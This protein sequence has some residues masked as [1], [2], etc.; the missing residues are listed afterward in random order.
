MTQNTNKT[1]KMA[2]MLVLVLTLTSSVVLASETTELDNGLTVTVYGADEIRINSSVCDINLA[3]HEDR[4]VPFNNDKVMSALSDMHGFNIDLNVTVYLLPAPPASINSSYAR[5]NTIY[6]A[7]GTGTIPA[8]TQAYITTHEMGHVLCSSYMDNSKSRWSEY[9]E[10]RGLNHD[11]NGPAAHHADRAREIV[12]E[13]FRFLFGGGLAT[14]TGSIE[15]HNM[16][17]PNEVD[18]LKEL[19][20]EFLSEKVVSN[21]NMASAK[22][23]PNPCNPR[24]TIK[25]ELPAG[26]A[27]AGNV[28]LSVFDVRGS[29]V[30]TINGGQINGNTVAVNWNGDNDQGMGVSSG[31]YLYLI[32]AG[33]VSARGAVSLVR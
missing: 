12:A 26:S 1:K 23:F 14:S 13:D 7:P 15:N 24:T 10:L 5:G 19:L 29:L 3:A 21:V 6:L 22:A 8:S 30:K 25:M 4:F 31:R 2:K 16:L 11:D 27:A 9:M 17:L 18:G 20:V 28:R 33:S 32:Q